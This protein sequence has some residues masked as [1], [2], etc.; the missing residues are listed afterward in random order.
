M[1]SG[2]MPKISNDTIK[3]EQMEEA[4]QNKDLEVGE[5]QEENLDNNTEAN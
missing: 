4:S 1:T 5:I 3:T 2:K